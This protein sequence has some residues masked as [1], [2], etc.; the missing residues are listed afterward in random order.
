MNE[1]DVILIF[2]KVDRVVGELYRNFICY[3]LETL[4]TKQEAKI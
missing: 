3:L 4:F 2:Q 1:D